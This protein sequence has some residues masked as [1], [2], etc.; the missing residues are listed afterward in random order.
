MYS[1]EQLQAFVFAYETG[2]FSAAGKKLGKAQ[3]VISQHIINLELDCG[4]ELFDRT[5][6]YPKLTEKGCKLLPFAQA[7]LA[8]LTRFDTQV[9]QLFSSLLPKVI[10]AIDIVIPSVDIAKILTNLEQKFPLIEI[11]VLTGSSHDVIDLIATDRATTGIIFREPN[12]PK[13]IDSFPLGSI[14][15]SV[16]AHHKHTLLNGAIEHIDQLRSHRQ[17]VLKTQN[18][19]MSFLNEAFSPEVWFADNYYTLMVM[20]NSHFGWT[21]LPEHIVDKSIYQLVK[22]ENTFTWNIN[23]DILQPKKLVS[24]PV[25]KYTKELFFEHCNYK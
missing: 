14:R 8:Q 22:I 7:T 17:L 11:E 12:L 18:N 3:S 4:I 24:D 21:L 10:L 5:G 9:E 2:S 15:F 16:F 25:H 6:K 20:A 19:K 13:E 23:V 1:I